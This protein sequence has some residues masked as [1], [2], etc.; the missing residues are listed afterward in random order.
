M[1][2][3]W[4]EAGLLRASAVKPVIT[5]VHRRLVIQ[6]LGRLRRHDRLAVSAS[7]GNILGAAARPGRSR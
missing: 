1:L 7:L 6:K 4:K 3:Q 2:A 5:T